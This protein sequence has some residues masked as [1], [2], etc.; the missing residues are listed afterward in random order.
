M[1]S[2]TVNAC[3]D[4]IAE[5]LDDRDHVRWAKEELEKL[6]S[7][8]QRE[9][10]TYKPE[11]FNVME[12]VTLSKGTLQTLP[13]DGVSLLDVSRNM[14]VDK[15]T[16]GRAVRVVKREIMDRE[17]PEWHQ[18]TPSSTVRHYMFDPR[19]PRRF[20]V[21]PPQP[22]VLNG[23]VEVLYTKAPGEM[24]SDQGMAVDEAWIGAIENFALSRA[25]LKNTE[26]TFNPQLAALFYQGFIAQMTGRSS[27]EMKLDP[28]LKNILH[29]AGR[30][31]VK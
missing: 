28:N 3:I 25:Y 6:V 18:A 23:S 1:A 2:L 9:I 13:A 5:R 22:A 12:V 24:I 17:S 4:R 10:F 31:D 21:S 29:N 14:G 30:E 8:G 7:D 19:N 15:A 27:A 26:Y 16:P 20:Y 11:L